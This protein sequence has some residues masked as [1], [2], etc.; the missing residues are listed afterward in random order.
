M[1]KQVVKIGQNL[2][3]LS[4]CVKARLEREKAEPLS[5][6]GKKATT[7][8][9][10]GVEDAIA[11]TSSFREHGLIFGDFNFKNIYPRDSKRFVKFYE[12]IEKNLYTKNFDYACFNLSSIENFAAFADGEDIK[13]Y[14]PLLQKAVAFHADEIAKSTTLEDKEKQR[15]LEAASNLSFSL[16]YF[17]ASVCDKSGTQEK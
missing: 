7:D 1:E 10:Y 16:G 6:L 15:R 3:T 11:V 12:E 13:R 14:A 5:T 17:Y 4:D 8:L 9:I 2:K